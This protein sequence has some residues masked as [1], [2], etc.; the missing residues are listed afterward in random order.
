MERETEKEER[1]ERARLEEKAVADAQ[2]AKVIVQFHN[3]LNLII[4]TAIP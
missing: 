4:L 3:P 1:L 2:K